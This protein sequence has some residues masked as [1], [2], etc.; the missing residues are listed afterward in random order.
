P[1]RYTT[2]ATTD[3]GE[4]RSRAQRE[5]PARHPSVRARITMANRPVPAASGECRAAR[6]AAGYQV[7]ESASRP[8]AACR[9]DQAAAEYL[10][11][12]AVPAWADRCNIAAHE[13]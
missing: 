10:V 7:A 13:T 1:R 5:Q 8:A 6:R 9:S 3:A 11:A 2:A 12:W 4:E